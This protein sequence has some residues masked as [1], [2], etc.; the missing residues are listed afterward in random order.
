M[1][2]VPPEI[3]EWRRRTG[4]ERYDEMWEG[5]LHIVAAPNREHQDFRWSL[6][7]FLRLKWSR[8]S[9]FRVHSEVNVASEGGWPKDYR[10]PD[11]VL[12]APDRFHI[13]KNEFF[14]GA[15][16]L[17]VEI[18]SPDDES[19]EKL[20]FYSKL[21]VEECWIIG[22]DSKV[23]E[24]YRWK[25][26]GYEMVCPDSEGWVRSVVTA[27]EMKASEDQKFLIR[28]PHSPETVESLPY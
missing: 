4:A 17:V 1:A 13:D 24:I 2:S 16:T 6:E 23:P 14:E 27:L 28:D 19:Y 20:D 3:L 7:T 9:E 15:P 26:A 21:G 10:I 22:R 11:L 25:E 5:V 8:A 12:L 18:R